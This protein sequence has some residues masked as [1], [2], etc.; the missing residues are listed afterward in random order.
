EIQ[1]TGGGP[2]VTG[3]RIGEPVLEPAEAQI[4][5][6]AVGDHR[7][8][9]G[10][11]VFVLHG[12]VAVVG[13]RV[14]VGQN[15][16]R[17]DAVGRYPSHEVQIEAERVTFGGTPVDLAETEFLVVGAG[18]RHVHLFLDEGDGGGALR[19]GR[20]RGCVGHTVRRGNEVARAIGQRGV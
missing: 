4:V 20:A 8:P 9:G 17:L 11:A 5:D 10:L 12:G 2:Q 7:S 19:G 15:T 3:A 14:A 1:R 16:L 18:H 13:E 6:R